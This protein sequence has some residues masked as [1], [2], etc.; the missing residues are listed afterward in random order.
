MTPARMSPPLR[1][2]NAGADTIIL[3]D[4]R[5]TSTR[6]GE[7]ARPARSGAEAALAAP[8]RTEDHQLVAGR[9]R[10]ADV[11]S[12]VRPDED[13]HMPTDAVLLV[14]RP[15]L[16]ARIAAV[17]VVEHR[18][19]RRALGLHPRRA[20]GVGDQLRGNEDRHHQSGA[21]TTE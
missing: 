10:A 16:Q 11:A 6:A 3:R 15:E 9:Q 8:D 18:L 13:P 14:D 4:D 21:A 12:L 7:T 5:P 17:E 2:R 1:R 20:A 19:D